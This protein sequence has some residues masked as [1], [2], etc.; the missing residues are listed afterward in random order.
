MESK[1]QSNLIEV[2]KSTFDVKSKEASY[3]ASCFVEEHLDKGD[4]FLELGQR[5][6]KLSFIQSG[7]VRVYAYHDGK[8]VTQ[9]IGQD[10]YFMTDLASFVLDI[11]ARWQIQAL[12]DV[13]I[14][15]LNKS[16]YK[17]FEKKF[18]EWNII[19]KRFISKCFIML[20]NRVFDFI[21]LSAE[22]RYL[23]FFEF[24][25]SLFNQVPLQYIASML[26]MTPETFSRIRAKLSS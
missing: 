24:N 11:P 10:G 5:C 23:K 4:L 16:D 7:I 21:S 3:I 26:G 15:T 25:K 2:L 6:N 14:L 18:P 20:E 12:T 1:Q 9:W 19:E 13:K 8:E 22:E 17:S